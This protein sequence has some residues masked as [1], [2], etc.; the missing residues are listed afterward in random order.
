MEKLRSQLLVA[1]LMGVLMPRLMLNI[2][3][4][5]DR[6]E[7]SEP[8]QTQMET[9]TQEPTQ[10]D[11]PVQIQPI[12]TNY[13]PVLVSDNRIV[14]MELE[15]YTLGVVLA[16]MPAS[17]EEE[18]LKAQAIAAR[19]YALRR[20][21]LGDRHRDMAVCTDSHCCQAYLTQTQYLQTRGNTENLQRIRKAVQATKGMVLTYGGTLAESTYFSCSGGRTE[22]AVAVWGTDIP[23]LQAVD[24]PGEERANAYWDSVYLTAADFQKVLNRKLN[25]T[26]QSW[27]GQQTRTDGDGVSTIVIGGIT[28]SGI[29]MRKILGLNSTVFTIKP[30]S[31]GVMIETFGKG[32]RVGMSQYG[33]DAMAAIGK[34]CEEILTYYYQ[35]TRIDK[36]E[37]IG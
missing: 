22:D 37:N 7:P 31:K 11:P 10:T 36:W 3:S 5:I 24:S 19:T 32:H 23:Y 20:Y 12:Q 30:D 13:I 17:F 35:G 2:G 1:F 25:G 28:Y 27:F 34:T 6:P 21:I 4:W 16:E 9:S 15:E 8:K 18:A 14:M 26:P 29:Q 33:A